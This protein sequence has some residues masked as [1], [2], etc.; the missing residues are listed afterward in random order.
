MT[1]THGD[2]KHHQHC[3]AAVQCNPPYTARF[4]GQCSECPGTSKLEINIEDGM[5]D[6]MHTSTDQSTS[7][8]KVQTV[9]VFLTISW[10]VS[11]NPCAMISLP[12]N[13]L[14]FLLAEEK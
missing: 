7:E 5:I 11:Q 3:L 12:N 2:M 4:L 9:D 14:Y 13:C 1:L 10:L 8:T 6:Q